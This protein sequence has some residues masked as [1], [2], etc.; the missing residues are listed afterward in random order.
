M[1]LILLLIIIIIIT[2]II[3]IKDKQNIQQFSNKSLQ[4]YFSVITLFKNYTPTF[5][6]FQNFYKELWQVNQFIYL[7]YK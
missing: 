5:F 6:T 2:L 4:K 1:S 3:N 7:V